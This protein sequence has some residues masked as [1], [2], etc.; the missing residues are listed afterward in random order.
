MPVDKKWLILGGSGQLGSTLKLELLKRG[1]KPTVFSSMELDVR[2]FNKT[3]D[4]IRAIG[5]DYVINCAAWTNVREAELHEDEAELLNGSAVG[6]IG[7]TT[8]AYG[9]TLVQ[10]STDYVFSG[11]ETSPYKV[12]DPV[13]PI[14]AYGRTKL[15]GEN[16]ISD[17][18]IDRCYVMRTAWLYGEYGTNF[19]KTILNKYISGDEKIEIVNDQFGNPTN[20]ID[21][22][23]QII[24]SVESE[25]PYG[26]YHAVNSGV[27]SWF[28]FALKAFELLNLNTEYLYAIPTTQNSPLVRPQNSSLDT[29]KWL[30]CGMKEMRPWDEALKFSICDIFTQVQM[31]RSS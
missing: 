22:A 19:I 8:H 9:G 26:T 18:G 21:L 16:L 5:P 6:N 29:S 10:I 28:G 15:I 27:V 11:N 24:E 13:N 2:D 3:S 12:S 25:I 17:M 31:E 4:V 1:I 14:N 20:A 7:A 30:E 23:Q